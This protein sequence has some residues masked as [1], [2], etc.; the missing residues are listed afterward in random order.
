MM[1]RISPKK[2]RKEKKNDEISTITRKGRT[3][4][5]KKNVFRT[6]SVSHSEV[7]SMEFYE[8]IWFL[9]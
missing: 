6:G 7:F 2:N 3:Y 8:F 9:G 1:L 5:E 4:K